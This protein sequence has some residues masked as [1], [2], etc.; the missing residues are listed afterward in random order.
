VCQGEGVDT[1]GNA[2]YG[3]KLSLIARLRRQ[4]GFQKNQEF[5]EGNLF[6]G[7]NLFNRGGEKNPD[8]TGGEIFKPPRKGG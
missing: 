8:E 7:P 2:V 6:A 1:R 5:W 3:P 4:N